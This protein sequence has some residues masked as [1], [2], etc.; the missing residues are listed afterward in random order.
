MSVPNGN[1][2]VKFDGLLIGRYNGTDTYELG[3]L[4]APMHE[5]TVS[6]VITDPTQTTT[7][8]VSFTG[9]DRFWS[10]GV[11]GRDADASEFLTGTKP[12]R[13]RLPRPGSSEMM[14]YRWI[15]HLEHDD[16]PAHPKPMPLEPG[17]LKTIIYITNG[18]V[19][20]SLLTHQFERSLD[21]GTHVPFGV[22]SDEM[23]VDIDVAAGQWVV[24]KS[25]GTGDNIFRIPII[26]NR[27]VTLWL[28]NTPTMP[29]PGGGP[30]HFQMYYSVFPNVP[31][32]KRYQFFDASSLVS[33]TEASSGDTATVVSSNADERPHLHSELEAG[34]LAA[35]NDSQPLHRIASDGGPFRNT[36]PTPICG[37]VDLDSGHLPLS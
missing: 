27:K 37:P 15:L 28:L 35:S 16:C 8:Q 29:M 24:L 19:Y 36:A 2:Q 18:Q 11:E 13:L 30:T 1:V 31:P 26:Q 7:A 6:Y 17:V 25:L 33:G 10:L 12:N 22:A 14:D 21:S 5:F 23:S 9:S 32:E 3:V 34:A 4:E 20:T